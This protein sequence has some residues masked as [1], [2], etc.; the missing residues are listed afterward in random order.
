MHY[1]YILK[2]GLAEELYTSVRTKDK[3]VQEAK[4]K[5]ASMSIAMRRGVY[6]IAIFNVVGLALCSI[7]YIFLHIFFVH[8]Y[9]FKNNFFVASVDGL[10]H[11][12][13]KGK[14]SSNSLREW[15][16]ANG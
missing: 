4:S 5:R 2:L 9:F 10:L 1:S 12:E 14:Q 7:H 3:Q 8:H 11:R 13:A 6:T 15:L 16:Q